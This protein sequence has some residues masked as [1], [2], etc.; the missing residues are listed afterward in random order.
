[1][2][3]LIVDDDLHIRRLIGIY[4]RDAGFEVTEAATGEEGLE[5][6]QREPFDIVLVDLIL[7]QYG[8]FRLCQKLKSASSPPRVVITTGDD[9]PQSRDLA[10]EAKADAFLAKPFTR[11]EL[12]A[13]VRPSP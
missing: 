4:L 3:L 1:M 12:L 10:A 2:K 8:G 9:S 6:A 5:V 11:E 13:A 7:P